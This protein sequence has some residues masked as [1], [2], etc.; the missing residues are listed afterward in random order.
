MFS[1]SSDNAGGW[2]GVACGYLFLVGD[3]QLKTLRYS[4]KD[5]LIVKLLR[6]QRL[7]HVII[8][9]D[10]SNYACIEEN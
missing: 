6:R 3:D 10:K 1:L 2:G 8:K 7:P 4:L 5:H 9:P